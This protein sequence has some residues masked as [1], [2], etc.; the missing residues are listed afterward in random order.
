MLKPTSIASILIFAVILAY[1]FNYF[2]GIIT[3][4][5][6]SV[7]DMQAKYSGTPSSKALASIQSV[8]LSAGLWLAKLV[9]NDRFVAILLAI[10]LILLG[11]ELTK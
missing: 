2:T 9:T 5:V 10:E 4:I 7:E 1:L 11:Y 3:S 6:N 8:I